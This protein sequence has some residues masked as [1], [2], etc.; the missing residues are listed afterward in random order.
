MGKKL[1]LAVIAMGMMGVS[2]LNAGDVPSNK[3]KVTPQGL[4]LTPK[5]ALDMVNKDPKKVLFV[6]VRTPEELYFIGY[7][8][9]IDINIPTAYIDYTKF[10]EKKDKVKYASTKNAKLLAQFDAA[11]KKKSL[12]KEDNIIVMCRSGHRS[13]KVAKILDGAGYKKVYSI[14]QG[15]EGDKDKEKHRTVN[16]WKNAGLPYTYKINKDK[17]ILDR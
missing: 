11:L 14:D 13:A 15:F 3:K 12:T 16:G 2:A 7:P 10:K 17:V 4:Y 8:N 6:D 9:A 5:E 1:L